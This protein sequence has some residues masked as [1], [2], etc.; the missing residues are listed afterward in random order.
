MEEKYRDIMSE[1][2]YLISEDIYNLLNEDYESIVNAITT[3]SHKLNKLSED[4]YED[5]VVYERPDDK[6]NFEFSLI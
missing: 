4:V 6:V 1:L 3:L 5:E 2:L